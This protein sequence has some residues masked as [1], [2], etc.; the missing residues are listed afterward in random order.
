MSVSPRANNSN[1]SS[2]N[3]IYDVAIVGAGISGSVCAALLARSSFKV[4]LID[5][6][7]FPRSKICGEGLM[8]AGRRLLETL[9]LTE[10]LQQAGA[11]SFSALRFHLPNERILELDFSKQNSKQLGCVL[12]RE[13]LDHL[14]LRFATS[15]KEVN[16]REGFKVV[17]SQIGS[18][19]VELILQTRERCERL[20]ARVLVAAD[21]IK[22]RFRSVG[23]IGRLS[24]GRRR[25]ALRRLYDNYRNSGQTVDV[26]CAKGVE[27]YVAPLSPT[28]ARIT[29]LS[30]RNTFTLSKGVDALY[31][32][33]LE[34]FPAILDRLGKGSQCSAAEA[35]SP[36][37]ARFT[38]CH[39]NRLVLVGDAAGAVDPVTGQGMTI[40]LRDAHLA[41]DILGRALE[42]NLLTSEHLSVFTKE[43][44]DYF[45]SSYQLGQ[46][47]L[48]VLRFPWLA[49]RV[50][51]ALT[52]SNQLSNKLIALAN[53]P[54]TAKQLSQI[55]KFRL[56]LGF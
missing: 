40:A 52:R 18:Q 44:E 10:K 28:Q 20:K 21:G 50:S 34:H 45:L 6:A 30:Y 5:K 12:S 48:R 56:L 3:N 27:A 42:K 36:V 33:L 54:R 4:A 43:R 13:S 2:F 37:S 22:S 53:D 41:A 19:G 23:G 1:Q 47:L 16:F 25:F 55:D 8:P 11:K 35:T 38:R 24:S 15:H 7:R 32:D 39:A 31:E 51:L 9:G 17:K 14:L 26:Y 49:R 46:N 29:L